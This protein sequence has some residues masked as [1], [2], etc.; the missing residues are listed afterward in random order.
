LSACLL[1]LLLSFTS[2]A[3]ATPSGT[4]G[5]AVAFAM[6]VVAT[7]IAVWKDD[8]TGVAQLAVVTTLS[9]GTAYGLK[10]IVRERRPDHS[11]WDS[12]PSTTSALASAPSSF[13]W[14]RYGWEW[15][16]PLFII[17]KYTSYS[18]DRAKKNRIWD[19][20]ASTVISWGY[21]ELITTRFH[22]RYGFYSDLQAGPDGIYASVNYRW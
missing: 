22:P 3:E 11:G 10:Q 6:P 7:G 1:A 19:G 21:N 20:L 4:S 5:K 18:M 9:V 8:W 14:N 13:V 2:A 15:G 16:L 12:F 17:S